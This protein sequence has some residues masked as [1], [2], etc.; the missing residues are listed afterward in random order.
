M[1]TREPDNELYDRG[2]ELVEA[3]AGIRRAA[4]EREA[5]R[6]IPAV[7]GCIES[8]L[9]EL[10]WATAELEVTTERNIARRSHDHDA[11]LAARR[12]YANLE[13]SL[14]DAQRAAAAARALARHTLDLD[15]Q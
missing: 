1:R 13:Q 15:A 8:A 4:A 14:R 3:A 12:R 7:L 6:A 11:P 2:F 10:L 9:S 5:V